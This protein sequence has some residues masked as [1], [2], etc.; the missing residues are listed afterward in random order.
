MSTPVAPREGEIQTELPPPRAMSRE[1]WRLA[2]PAIVQSFLLTLVFLV[3]RAM[4]GRHSSEALASMQVSGPL[5]WA[6]TATLG[7][8]H[9]AAVA[10]VGRAY[11]AKEM[12]R[13]R[14]AARAALYVAAAL[15][16]IAA[17][18]ATASLPLIDVL[19]A[20][21]GPAVLREVHGYLSVVLPALP[22]LMLA[23]AA[24]AVHHAVGDTRTPL[25]VGVV[26]N[27]VNALGNLWLIF[28]GLGVP[29]LGARG[30]A[31]ASVV[32]VA[33][34]A[35]LLVLLLVRGRGHLGIRGRGGERAMI[36]RMARVAGPAF[37]ERIVQH[38]G[39]Q[40][41]VLMIGALGSVAMAANQA[42]V[43]I[44][45]ICF[46]S[47]DGFGVAAAAICAQRLGAGEPREASRGVRLSTSYAVLL[48]GACAIAFLVIP[49][50]LTEAFSPDPAIVT[51]A[52]PCLRIAAFAQPFMA[53][54]VVV[55]D[56][57]RGAGATRQSF[58][59]MLIGSF[60]VRLGATYLACFVWDL[61]LAGAW[62]G[63]TADWIV[64]TALALV[65]FARGRWAS[66]E[67]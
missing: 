57:L 5:V 61:G 6:I 32:A 9:I 7:A 64:R 24:A 53:I 38:I 55:L 20:S 59:I 22:A 29:A 49:E 12:D 58:V 39:F 60:V 8:V 21:A 40:G 1:V 19:F 18:L 3:D 30:A 63:S 66:V 25:V 26:G 51:T 16:A 35:A 42:L 56:G 65:V 54:A 52:V 43:G 2:G 13:A 4:L 28:G 45:S 14:T 50:L 31:I 34:E 37:A 27:V 23:G 36:A 44:E 33:L 41:Y 47:A 10:T 62:I 46:L 67:V 48:L 17:I 15:G 11:G